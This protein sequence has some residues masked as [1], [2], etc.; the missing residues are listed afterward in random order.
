MVVLLTLIEIYNI[1]GFGPGMNF[2]D[3]DPNAE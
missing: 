3:N 2:F 1:Q